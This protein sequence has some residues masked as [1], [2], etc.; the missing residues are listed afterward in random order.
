M[1][2]AR[3]RQIADR[4]YPGRIGLAALAVLYGAY[5]VVRGFGGEDWAAARAHTADIV[6]IERRLNLF[7]ERDIQD[8]ASALPGVPALLGFLYVALHFAGTAAALHLGA[9]PPPARV[10]VPAHDADREHRP[11]AGRLRALPGGAAA[12]REHGL[13]RHGHLHG[14]DLSSDLLGSFYNPIAAVP[15]LHFGYAAD[16]RRRARAA[17]SRRSY[18]IAARSTPRSCS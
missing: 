3:I 1:S 15:S 17:A 16:R 8:L 5:E 7:V 2:F 9:S 6:A 18:R 14:L 13:R 10:P 4:P 12:P 11:R